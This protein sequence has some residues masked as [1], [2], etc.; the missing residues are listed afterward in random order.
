MCVYACVSVHVLGQEG[1]VGENNE[2]MNRLFLKRIQVTS[3]ACNQNM[4]ISIPYY[5]IL[6]CLWPLL[7]IFS[8][9]IHVCFVI[10]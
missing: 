9:I 3:I 6:I 2:S 4:F 10:S 8:F 5:L 1:R 7:D